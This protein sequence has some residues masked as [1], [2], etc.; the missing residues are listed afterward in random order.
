ML[1]DVNTIKEG[2]ILAKVLRSARTTQ[3]EVVQDETN[4]G[5]YKVACAADQY[6]GQTSKPVKCSKKLIRGLQKL[7]QQWSTFDEQWKRAA[8]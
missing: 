4:N 6:V 5:F 7:C 8:D 1:L 2:G 3:N